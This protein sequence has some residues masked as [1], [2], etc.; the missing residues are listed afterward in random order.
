MADTGKFCELLHT[1]EWEDGIHADVSSAVESYLA[2][3][4]DGQLGLTG[5]GSLLDNAKDVNI[6]ASKSSDSQNLKGITIS[7]ARYASEDAATLVNYVIAILEYTRLCIPLKAAKDKV[8]AIKHEQSEFER[9]KMERE[10]E[11]NI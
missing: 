10:N 5:E 2:K 3:G 8:E 11:V 7:G 1:I 6:A 4:K 9:R